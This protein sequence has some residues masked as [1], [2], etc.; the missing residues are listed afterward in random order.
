MDSW[1]EDDTGEFTGDQ[2]AVDVTG[3]DDEKNTEDFGDWG[4][5]ALISGK[6]VGLE[7]LVAGFNLKLQNYL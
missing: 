4:G 5:S 7:T 1:P 6:A 3:I 2:L